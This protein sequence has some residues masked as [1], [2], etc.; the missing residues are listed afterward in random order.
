MTHEPRYVVSINPQ[1]CD[2]ADLLL[3]TGFHWGI[4]RVC[5]VLVPVH[6]PLYVPLPPSQPASLCLWALFAFRS[7]ATIRRDILPM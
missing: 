2:L 7:F 3:D 4:L 6:S 1:F 5:R